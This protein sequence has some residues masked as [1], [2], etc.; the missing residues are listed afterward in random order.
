M[1]LILF[2]SGKLMEYV[3]DTYVIG[4]NKQVA[5]SDLQK[6]GDKNYKIALLKG[7]EI[8]SAFGS[9]VGIYKS[10]N[11]LIDELENL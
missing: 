6:G 1:I 11:A 3:V 9:N 10:E 4:E 7:E 8:S 5:L 2:L